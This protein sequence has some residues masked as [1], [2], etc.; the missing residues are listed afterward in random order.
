M[1]FKVIKKLIN[2]QICLLLYDIN[3][4]NS[5]RLF[6]VKHLHFFF[7]NNAQHIMFDIKIICI[8]IFFLLNV[9]LFLFSFEML[10]SRDLY[11]FHEIIIVDQNM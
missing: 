11:R 3:R 5:F 7:L 2:A 10:G 4:R 1:Q 6:S 8:N 9:S